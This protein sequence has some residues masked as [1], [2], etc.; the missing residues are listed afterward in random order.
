MDQV[1]IDAVGFQFGQLGIQNPVH[2]SFGIC[3]PMGKLGGDLYF[4]PA[5]V[6]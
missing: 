5:A 1:I 4:I 2:I 6:F 3:A